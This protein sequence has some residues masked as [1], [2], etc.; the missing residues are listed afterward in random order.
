MSLVPWRMRYRLIAMTVASL[1]AAFLDMA[2]VLAMMPLMQLLTISTGLPRT[3]TTYIV[4]VVHS[5]DRKHLLLVMTLAICGLFILKDIVLVAIRWWSIGQMSRAAAA[6]QSE[7]LA[8]YTHASYASHRKRSRATITQVVANTTL[9]AVSTPLL[10]IIN[11]ITDLSSSVLLLATLIAVSPVASLIAVVVFGGA[12]FLMTKLIKPHAL[13]AGLKTL[14]NNTESWAYLNPA[15]EGFRESRIF[16]REDSFVESYRRNRMA[17]TYPERIQQVL[18]ELPR[19]LME[20]VM[21]VGILVISLILFSTQDESVAFGTLGVFAAAAA[22]IGPSLNRV[23]AAVNGLRVSRSAVVQLNEAMDDLASAESA[24]PDESDPI[25]VDLDG[26]IHVNDVGFH[27]PDS[28]EPVLSKVSVTIKRGTTI[29]LVGSSGAGKSTFAD[30]LLG[31]QQP[32]QG[33]IIV[34]G[35]DIPQ[36]PRAWRRNVSAVSQSVYLWNTSLRDLITFGAPPDQVDPKRL[37]EAIERAQLKAFIDEMPEGLDTIVGDGGTRLSG[38]QAQRVGIARALY[39]NPRVL[40][41][42]EATSA[43]DNETEHEITRT[44]D[45]LHGQLTMIIIA[46]RL[47]TVK[48]ADEIL[49]FSRGRLAGRGTMATLQAENAEFAR[50][51]ELGSL[52]LDGETSSA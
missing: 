14:D 9:I 11:I 45:A 40:I 37:S 46:H 42:D 2:G 25:A 29:A 12:A 35:Y 1:A 16:G 5:T 19:Y 26:D 27:Y 50:L 3:V 10:S 48:N 39:V 24:T 8:R 30:L 31:L 4:P 18:G 43:L 44:L 32:T 23:V 21:V 38:G 49:F 28:V 33:Q 13:R 7:V 22:R 51:V 15:I 52:D 36:H 34:N 47:S 20:I 17:N 6:A 41:L